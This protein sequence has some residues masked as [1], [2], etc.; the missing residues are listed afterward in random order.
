MVGLGGILLGIET[1][2]PLEA[3]RAVLTIFPEVSANPEECVGPRHETSSL[4][5]ATHRWSS[6]WQRRYRWSR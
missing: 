6:A 3:W 5:V 4:S 1:I 2:L